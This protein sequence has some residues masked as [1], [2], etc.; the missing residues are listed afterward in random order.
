[1]P[2]SPIKSEKENP[3]YKSLVNSLLKG[4]VL[5]IKCSAYQWNFKKLFYN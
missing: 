1:M 2:E 4:K 3:E 5:L